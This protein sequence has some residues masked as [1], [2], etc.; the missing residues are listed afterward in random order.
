RLVPPGDEAVLAPRVP[1]RVPERETELRATV[2]LP[3]ELADVRHAQCQA[4]NEPDREFL[5]TH[6][7]ERVAREVSGRE[8]L[9]DLTRL[10]SPQ[11]E[12]GERGGLVLDLHRAVVG[13]VLPDP[14]EIVLAEG[15]AGNDPESI[16]SEPGHREVALDP[17]ARIEHLRV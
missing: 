17:S 3:A 8:R 1:E 6:V 16:V 15:G 9:Q 2:E 12:A 5:C 4:R 13:C 7:R 14:R 10:R 11:T